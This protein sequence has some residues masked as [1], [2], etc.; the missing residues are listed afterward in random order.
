MRKTILLGA[1]LILIQIPL[2]AYVLL[3]ERTWGGVDRDGAN[4]VAV[5]TDGSVYVTGVTRSFGAGGDDAF[6]LKY[7]SSGVLQWQRTYGTAPDA[8][9]SGSEIGIDVAAA[10]DGSG[11]IVLGNYRDGNIFLAKFSPAGALLWDRTW[12]GNQEGA[13]AIAIAADGTIYVAGITFSFDVDQGDAFLVSFTSSGAL[14]WQ[15]TWGGPFFDVARGVAV[16][17]DGNVFI[18]GETLFTANAAFLV[19]FDNGGTVVWQREWGLD[20]KGGFP[21]DDDTDGNAVAAAPDGGAYIV[22]ATTGTGVDSN[23][24][25]VRF[26]AAGNFIWQ[27]VG[28]PGFGAA[29]DVAVG[30][31]G[32][33]HIT[34]GVLG[35]DGNPP[36]N[37]FVW[38]LSAAGKGSDAA[39]WGGDDPFVSESGASIAVAPDGAIVVA[40]IAGASPYTF[41]RGSKNAKAARTFINTIAGT[42]TTP[43]GAVNDPAAIVTIPAGSETFAGD[44]DA[45]LIRVQ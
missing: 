26:D 13:S 15:R 37:A 1:S 38:S 36:G 14:N 21:E 12:G 42:I 24:V 5:A 18:T 7:N 39:L 6:L 11:V 23:L 9:N 29:L 34:G 35:A 16:A 8:E 45:F 2:L 41:S 33:L 17:T 27:K 3:H 22:G 4:G 20:G 28:G 32:S 25:A 19:K 40:G 44:T 30:A 10:P 31:D 43:A